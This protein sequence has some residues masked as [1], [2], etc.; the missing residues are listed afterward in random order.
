MCLCLCFIVRFGHVVALESQPVTRVGIRVDMVDAANCLFGQAIDG[1][2]T[3]GA[4]VTNMVG[5]DPPQPSAERRPDY[6]PLC[7][8]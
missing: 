2:R 4:L 5:D 8:F 1:D 6:R 7:F 3:L